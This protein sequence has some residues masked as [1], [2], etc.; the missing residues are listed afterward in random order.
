L[1]QVLSVPQD[2]P[3]QVPYETGFDDL[4]LNVSPESGICLDHQQQ[5]FKHEEDP[6][7]LQQNAVKTKPI[8]NSH[9]QTF[10]LHNN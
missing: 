5:F 7:T 10:F 4:Q 3:T 2:T 8:S 1:F 6:L 9:F